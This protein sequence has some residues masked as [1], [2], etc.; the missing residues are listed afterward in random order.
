MKKIIFTCHCLLNVAA[1]VEM[2]DLKSMEAEEDLRRRFV[3]EAINSGIQIIQLPCPEFMLYGSRRWGHTSNQFDNPFFREESRKLLH[4]YVLQC[5]E[6]L[7]DKR[8]FKVLG[9]IGIDGSPS[10]GV[11]Y[12]GVGNWGGSY[13]AER[14]GKIVENHKLAKKSGIYIRVLRELLKENNINVPVV[15][16]FAEEE[17]RIFDLIR[18]KK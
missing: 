4:P 11:K 17:E 8:R 1:K 14:W 13:G 12:T 3:T 18:E 9:F 2:D 7:S 16:L 6:Y 10:C 15:G 5:R